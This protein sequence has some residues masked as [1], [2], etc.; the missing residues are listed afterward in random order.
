MNYLPFFPPA[1]EICNPFQK[2]APTS[3]G[4]D[5]AHQQNV[6]LNNDYHQQLQVFTDRRNMGFKP[7]LVVQSPHHQLLNTPSDIVPASHIQMMTV[8]QTANWIRTLG[9][10]WGWLQAWAYA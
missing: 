3:H 2:F 8:D 7:L 10:F 4:T 5:Y 9:L 6:H 1:T